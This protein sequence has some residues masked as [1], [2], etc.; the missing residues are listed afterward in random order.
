MKGVCWTN[1]V[2]GQSEKYS[3]VFLKQKYKVMKRVEFKIFSQ[4]TYLQDHVNKDYRKTQMWNATWRGCYLTESPKKCAYKALGWNQI[5]QL[6]IAKLEITGRLKVSHVFQGPNY[7]PLSELK[8]DS[9]KIM[10]KIRGCIHNLLYTK[11]EHWYKLT[12][13]SIPKDKSF[14]TFK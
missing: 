14:N 9:S 8:Q 6:S 11:T 3:P 5:C 10:M 13:L 12:L 4:K 2:T 1:T 7:T